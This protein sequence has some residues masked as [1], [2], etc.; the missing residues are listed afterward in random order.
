MNRDCGHP[1]ERAEEEDFSPVVGAAAADAVHMA[2]AAHDEWPDQAQFSCS[3]R[4]R[5]AVVE[6]EKPVSERGNAESNDADA[7]DDETNFA[8]W[9]ELTVDGA[10]HALDMSQSRHVVVGPPI[11]SRIDSPDA[12]TL[13][14]TASSRHERVSFER[15]RRAKKKRFDDDETLRVR[16]LACARRRR[17]KRDDPG[18]KGDDEFSEDQNGNA[19][20]V[21]NQERD[22]RTRDVRVK[23]SPRVDGKRRRIYEKPP[24]ENRADVSEED[25]RRSSLYSFEAD[26]R[27]LFDSPSEEES[28]SPPYVT[29]VFAHCCLNLYHH[30]GVL[31]CRRA[32]PAGERGKIEIVGETLSVLRAAAR[33]RVASRSK[34][35]TMAHER[36]DANALSRE[37]VFETLEISANIVARAMS[38]FPRHAAD[39]VVAAVLK[40]GSPSAAA[41]AG[42][43]ALEALRSPETTNAVAALRTARRFERDRHF[44]A[45]RVNLLD[46]A[47]AYASLVPP[48]R[49]F[50]DADAPA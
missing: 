21:S 20:D 38:T 44:D 28:P 1:F 7:H 12:P 45:H 35:S 10:T 19:D 46:D 3:I 29:I 50:G 41:R 26:A 17:E 13:Q 16:V 36:E 15:R 6:R 27:D 49:R 2:F 40:N 5:R 4:V 11:D 37:D 32:S 18:N 42:S 22:V 24:S 47:M 25:N 9:L 43:F 8:C 30:P 33:E 14:P 48:K 23:T 39:A 31:G 34:K